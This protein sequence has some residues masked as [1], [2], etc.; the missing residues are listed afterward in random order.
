MSGM[1]RR[2][3]IALVAALACLA[4]PAAR[5]ES[6]VAAL[7][8]S[9]V[10]ITSN[11]TG[12]EIAVFGAVEQDAG[13]ISRQGPYDIAVVLTGP[14]KTFVTRQK[15]RLLG[16]YVN[17]DARTYVDVP[18]FYSIATTRPI[19]D[20][21]VEALLKRFQL[22]LDYILLPE[23][24]IGGV[25][26]LAG[27]ENFRD[28]FLRLKQRAGVYR[29]DIGRVEFMTDRVYR[30]NMTIPA[31]VPVGDY[32]VDVYLFRDEALLAQQ[33]VTFGVEKIGFEQFMYQAAF[34]HS[35]AYG[36]GAVALA[37]LTGWVAGVIFR[38]D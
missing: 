4:G 11:F 27:H 23:S 2:L 15:A 28:A 32:T 26:V 5:A 20:I 14:K 29:E 21:A 9:K 3:Y 18:S 8:S 12:T 1:A 34:T 6:L 16:L 25:E 33:R 35:W 10:F 38:K 24:V 31:N 22:G 17:R 13:T 36:L 7:S 19:A 30:V 37:L